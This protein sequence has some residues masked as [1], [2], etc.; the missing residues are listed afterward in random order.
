MVN[1][2]ETESSI[3]I[4]LEGV[5]GTRFGEFLNCLTRSFFEIEGRL[6]K[7]YLRHYKQIDQ[8]SGPVGVMDY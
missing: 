1:T 7:D 2:S 3:R 8:R 6:G 4:Q 5:P